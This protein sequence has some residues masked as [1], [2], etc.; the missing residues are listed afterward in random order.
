MCLTRVLVGSSLIIVV[1]FSWPRL[2]KKPLKWRHSLWQSESVTV[3]HRKSDDEV[4]S[5]SCPRLNLRP[6]SMTLSYQCWTCLH[7][8]LSHRPLRVRLRCFE[9][10][11][12]EHLNAVAQL[13]AKA[14]GLFLRLYLTTSGLS[15]RLIFIHLY[16]QDAIIR[17][18]NLDSVLSRYMGS[19]ATEIFRILSL[20]PSNLFS[21]SIR[22]C[23]SSM[24]HPLGG[25]SVRP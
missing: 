19:C 12:D 5:N 15:L 21:L 10:Q 17:T 22:F 3:P 4:K 23:P 9:G 11:R 14:D 25:K 8:S 24:L 7:T 2:P 18:A 1:E 6:L 16:Q 13:I 20:R